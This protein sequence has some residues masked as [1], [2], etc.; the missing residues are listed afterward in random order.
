MKKVGDGGVGYP[1]LAQNLALEHGVGQS[2]AQVRK[3]VS[4]DIYEVGTNKY[5]N[6]EPKDY[7]TEAKDEARLNKFARVN[8]GRMEWSRW[9]K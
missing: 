2:A 9:W 8:E 7:P 3:L 5:Y 6:G 1:R 4:G